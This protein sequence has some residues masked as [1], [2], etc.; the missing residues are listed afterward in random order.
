[1]HPGQT[2]SLFL[3][4]DAGD[5]RYWHVICE[6]ADILEQRP[7]PPRATLLDKLG[8]DPQNS[9]VLI[10]REGGLFPHH[11]SQVPCCRVTLTSPPAHGLNPGGPPRRSVAI[12]RS[13]LSYSLNQNTY[14]KDVSA[15]SSPAARPK[16]ELSA[17]T[18][19]RLTVVVLM[20]WGPPQSAEAG[21]SAGA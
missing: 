4:V 8:L 20:D 17:L 15:Q 21:L 14:G 19:K 9:V 18:R 5:S 2:S 11:P 12:G 16:K 6:K 1:M 13:G 3:C 7:P 10:T